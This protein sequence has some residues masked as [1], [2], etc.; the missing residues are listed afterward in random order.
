VPETINSSICV[1]RK[2]GDKY[3]NEDSGEVFD[4]LDDYENVSKQVGKELNELSTAIGNA[5]QRLDHRQK[6][7]NLY[8]LGIPISHIFLL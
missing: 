6:T 8:F 7:S 1:I 5:S 2:F 4:N 3:K